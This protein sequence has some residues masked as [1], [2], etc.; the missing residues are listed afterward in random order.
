[1][2]ITDIALQHHAI[3][4]SLPSDC[5]RVI[6][7][8]A[9]YGHVG[10]LEYLLPKLRASQSFLHVAS[11]AY[12]TAIQHGHLDAVQ[13]LVRNSDRDL[14]PGCGWRGLETAEREDDEHMCDFIRRYRQAIRR[15]IPTSEF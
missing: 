13:V 2:K 11:K 5:E 15:G 9:R 14:E 6:V 10:L 3:N 7:S 12:I 4:G 1:V 8:A